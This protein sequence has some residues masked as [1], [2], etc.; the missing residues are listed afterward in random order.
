MPGN[1]SQRRQRTNKPTHVRGSVIASS[2]SGWLNAKM[3]LNDRALRD[4][5][6]LV[7]LRIS[8]QQLV[9]A[10]SEVGVA[11]SV[12]GLGEKVAH[13]FPDEVEGN[14][15][16]SLNAL[17]NFGRERGL[18]GEGGKTIIEEASSSL[19]EIADPAWKDKNLEKWEALS[20]SL[21]EAIDVIDEDHPILITAK[22][23]AL[24]Y[25]HQ[26][27][28]LESSLI[29]D[30]RPIFSQDAS[31]IIRLIVSHV[32]TI[33]YTDASKTPS[34]VS[35]MMDSEDI[36]LLRQACER[37]KKKAQTITEKMA[38]FHPIVLPE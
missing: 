35:V 10:A 1:V 17:W 25:A 37:A 5:E 32:L 22:A 33:E 18:T 28:Y 9:Q 13:R 4:I 26:H 30:V 34:V 14:I 27:L 19:E 29:T 38:D 16:R 12:S 21:A 3:K 23:H 7:L 6:S 8:P 20:P 31:R 15:S 36:E 24:V 11:T 2:A